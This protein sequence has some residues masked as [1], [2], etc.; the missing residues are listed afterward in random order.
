MVKVARASKGWRA[1]GMVVIDASG[2]ESELEPGPCLRKLQ[3]KLML[4]WQLLGL[5]PLV[6]KRKLEEGKHCNFVGQWNTLWLP[7]PEIA[8]VLPHLLQGRSRDSARELPT[9]LKREHSPEML[10]GPVPTL[11]KPRAAW[12]S[13]QTRHRVPISDD[14]EIGLDLSRRGEQ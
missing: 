1:E 10:V 4:H 13:R 3:K 2:L 11:K 7:K 12:G 9:I 5:R 8:T 6:P 14:R